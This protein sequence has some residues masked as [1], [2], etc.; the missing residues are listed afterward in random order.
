MRAKKPSVDEERGEL[1]GLYH[2]LQ[3]EEKE[4]EDRLEAVGKR[5]REVAQKFLDLKAPAGLE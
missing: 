1:V 3:R 2:E 5:K 4:L